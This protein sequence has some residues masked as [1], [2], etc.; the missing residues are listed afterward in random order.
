[1]A[2][3]NEYVSEENIKKYDL[4]S[5]YKKWS[6]WT[7]P[8][9]QFSW[10]FDPYRD[11]YYIPMEIGREE[12][13]NQVRGVLFYNGIQWNVMV[14]KEKGGGLSFTENP[15]RQIWGLIYIKHPG[16]GF[17]PEDEIVPVLKEALT[18]YQ[19]LGIGTPADLNVVTS[20]TF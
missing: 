9:F 1:M 10:T 5:L 4:E 19:V 14:A 6:V 11:S 7:P 12:E 15:Y 3:L 2:F 8:R 17:V 13:S 18:A 20:F 16:G